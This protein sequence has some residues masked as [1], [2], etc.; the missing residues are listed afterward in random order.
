[1]TASG[2]AA[3]SAAAANRRAA[4]ATL[5]AWLALVNVGAVLIGVV[6]SDRGAHGWA[7]S[8]YA[9]GCGVLGGCAETFGHERIFDPLF[10]FTSPY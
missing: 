9:D 3:W 8:R 6:T 7:G 10:E 1:L 2:I 4:Q 5:M